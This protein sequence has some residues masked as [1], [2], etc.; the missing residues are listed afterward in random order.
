MKYD[1]DFKKS[2]FSQHGWGK[3]YCVEVKRAKD[4]ISV[5]D[6]KSSTEAILSFTTEEWDAFVKGVKSGEFDI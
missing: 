3:K 6:S 4:S 2:S 5:R 1:I